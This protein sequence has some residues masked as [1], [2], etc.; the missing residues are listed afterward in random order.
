[1]MVKFLGD[2]NVVFIWL[3]GSLWGRNWE[4]VKLFVLWFLV[5][6]LIVCIFILKL[7]IMLFGD[8]FV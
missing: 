5:L 6:L 8:E 1:M 3:I 7:D 4:E 2:V